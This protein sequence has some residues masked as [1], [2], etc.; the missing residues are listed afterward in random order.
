MFVAF[1]LLALGS[2]AQ[3]GARHNLTP[4]S[5]SC[6]LA[7]SEEWKTGKTYIIQGKY[8]SDGIHGSEVELTKCDTAIIA[9]I[10]DDAATRVSAFHEVFETKCGVHLANDGFSGQFIGTVIRKKVQLFG[11][12]KAMIMP[13]FVIRDILTKELDPASITCPGNRS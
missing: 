5:A 10:T 7:K 6:S 2:A 1:A 12:R 13:V 11:L 8:F 9:V 4:T 3:E